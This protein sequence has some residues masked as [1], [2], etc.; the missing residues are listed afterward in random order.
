VILYVPDVS[1]IQLPV[2]RSDHCACRPGF[3]RKA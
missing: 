2:N 3:H 1:L